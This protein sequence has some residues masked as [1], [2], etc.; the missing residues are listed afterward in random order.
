MFYK[1][2]LLDSILKTIKK[3]EIII[4]T[5][6]RRVGKTTIIHKI[7]ED[8]P[9]DNKAFID[10]EN[11]IEQKIFEEIDFNNIIFNFKEFG[12]N[13][14]RKMYI[15][16]D[17]IQSMPLV[18]K[19]IKYL[20]DNYDIK[21]ILT[22]SSSFY[23]KNLFSESLSG[24]KFLFELFPLDFQEFLLFKGKK[25]DFTFKLNFSLKNQFSYNQH[26]KL[27]DEYLEYGGFP[28]VALLEENYLKKQKLNDIFKSYFE[29]DVKTLADFRQLNIFRDM[30][31]LLMQ[32]SGSNLEI[33]K[34]ASE[35]GI[36]RDTV[37]SF[38]SF[39]E[40]T[41][42][43]HLISPISNNID[44]EISGSKKIY[45][46]DTGFLNHLAK[47]GEGSVFENSVFL[48]LK[49]YGKINYYK[50]R[51]SGEIDFIL[52]KK[53][54]FESKMTGTDLDIRDA[55]KTAKLL[56]IK[57]TYIISKNY[58]HSENIIPALYL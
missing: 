55:S 4:L 29:K 50:R 56:K 47:T 1:R 15:F 48:N 18:I 34:I 45:L 51:N 49:K 7:F 24:R 36:S 54:A 44:R 3:K 16:I 41:Y 42:F 33:S 28:E 11:P 43:I 52:N 38:L 53:I 17:E 30:I 26:K 2:R 5:G 23:L 8:I 12:I 14:K 20:Y 31:L 25:I 9:S 46:C 10:L 22:G 6:M 35:L 57:K 40:N 37:Y 21:F 19:P 13:P 27:F 39:L 32:R 58:S